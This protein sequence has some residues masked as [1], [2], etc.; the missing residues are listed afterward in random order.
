M[1]V[2]NFAF[3]EVHHESGN[4]KANPRNNEIKSVHFLCSGFKIEFSLKAE[5]IFSINGLVIRVVN[6]YPINTAITKA[7]KPIKSFLA[8]VV[9]ALFSLEILGKNNNNIQSVILIWNLIE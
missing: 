1:S 6:W 3:L 4:V 2:S 8:F 9:G 5:N 7:K